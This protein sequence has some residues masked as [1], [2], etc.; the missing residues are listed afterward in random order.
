MKENRMNEAPEMAK[1]RLLAASRLKDRSRRLAVGVTAAAVGLLIILTVALLDYRFLLPKGLRISAMAGLCAIILWG[2]HRSWRTWQRPTQLKEAALDAEAQRPELGCEISTAAEYLTGERR[3]SE[4]YEPELAAA[5]QAKAAK[6]LARMPV[7]YAMKIVRPALGLG[8]I[9]MAVLLFAILA[10]GSLTAF[11]RAVAPWANASYTQVQVKPG[12]IEI[13]IGRDVEIKSLFSGRTPK[14]AHFQWL[15]EGSAKWHTVE[16][17]RNDQNEYVHPVKNVRSLIKYRVRGSDAVSADYVVQPYTPPEVREWRLG[18]EYP[19]YTLH[20]KGVQTTPDISVVRATIVSFQIKPSVKLSKARLRFSN[21]LPTLDLKESPGGLWGADLKIAKD[22]EFW[23]ELADVKGRIGGNEVP[24]SIKALP[25]EAPKVEILEPGQDRRADA[26]NTIPVKISVSDDFGVGEIKLVYHRLGSPEQFVASSRQNETNAE[27]TVDLPLSSMGLKEYELVVYHAEAR[28]NNTLDGPGIG[29]SQVY[30]VEITNEE[31]ALCKKPATPGTKVNLLVVQKQIISDTA[32]L[33]TTAVAGKFKDLAARQKDA[34]DFG[35]IYLDGMS[36]VGAPAEAVEEMTAAL[37]DMK[38]AQGFLENMGR[39]KALPPEEKALA[40]LYHLLK[41][42]PELKDLPTAP[43]VAET[44]K[45]EKPTTPLMKVVLEAIKKKQKEQPDNKEIAEALE[46]AKNLEQQASLTLGV[47]HSGS[48]SG[49]G[50]GEVKLDRSGKAAKP[51]QP[52]KD[53]KA[54]QEGKESKEAKS[55]K[56]ARDP[57]DGKGGKGGKGDKAG[58]EGKEGQTDPKEAQKL[59]EKQKELSKEAKALAEKLA[60]IAGKDSRLG[61]GAAKKMSEAAEKL[62]AAAES[63][64]S[65][66]AQKAGTQGA[67]GD[68]ALKVTIALLERI[69]ENR[70][71]LGNVANEDF[72][73]EYEGVISEYLKKLSYAE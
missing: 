26:T 47:Q 62:R 3:A 15:D 70:P 25:D 29:R 67:Q 44:P 55:D 51:P 33:G 22:A 21:G 2:V 45:E 41:L 9:T 7:P 72:P 66:D 35:K 42:L 39:D 58:K 37:R 17:G 64:Q 69:L 24:Y 14:A 36:E 34:A 38:E 6:N 52:G 30:F 28:D 8:L 4:A 23:I 46:E 60:R 19:A 54:E 61:Q 56:N 1:E 31:G 18:L 53:G 13:P 32:A 65:G 71:E 16:L 27:M 10:S 40:R 68:A 73:K 48:G 12:D 59:A 20:P 63:A 43:K 5:L 57:K 50:E 11:K 49:K